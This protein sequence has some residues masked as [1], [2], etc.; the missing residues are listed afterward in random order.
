MRI[1]KAYKRMYLI[2]TANKI[3]M[4]RSWD[5]FI[6]NRR[7][8]AY[9]AEFGKKKK[10]STKRKSLVLGSGSFNKSASSGLFETAN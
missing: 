7:R 4:A 9:M 10:V 6:E 5:I 3:L 8:D 1:Q 2:R